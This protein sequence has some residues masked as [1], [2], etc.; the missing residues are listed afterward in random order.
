MIAAEEIDDFG[1]AEE[2][3]PVRLSQ[4]NLV[5]FAGPFVNSRDLPRLVFFCR[6]RGNLTHNAPD[7]RLLR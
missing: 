1:R 5:V 6:L 7:A 3:K 2:I 4:A